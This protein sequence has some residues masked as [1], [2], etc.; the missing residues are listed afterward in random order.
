MPELAAVTKSGRVQIINCLR[1]RSA[2]VR[3]VSLNALDEEKEED[4]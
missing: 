1:Y 2:L 3:G 4:A